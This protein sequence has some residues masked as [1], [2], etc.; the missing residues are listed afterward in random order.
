MHQTNTTGLNIV[1]LLL[2]NTTTY[3]L[4]GLVKTSLLC[5]YAVT[6]V[7]SLGGNFIICIILLIRKRLRT[8][9]N[10]YIFNLSCCDILVITICV[11]FTAVTNLILYY[12]PFGQMVCPLVMYLQLVTVLQRSLLLVAMTFDKYYAIWQP[13]KRRLGIKWTK[14]LIGI[15]WCISAILSIPTAIHYRI[16]Y[17]PHE[18]GSNGLCIE[19]WS[20]HVARYWYSL[21]ILFIQYFI[22]LLILCVTSVHIGIIIMVKRTPGE[23]DTNRD[24]RLARSKRTVI[25][26]ISSL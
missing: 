10:I 24:K 3:G 23:A 26:F 16:M 20:S 14:L 7:T 12:W 25:Y 5:M 1:P 8:V 22:P 19:Q 6:T 2:P 15:L 18:P 4:N 11:P 17:F 9:T 13:L 21:S